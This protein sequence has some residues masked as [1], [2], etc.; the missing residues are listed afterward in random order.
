[1]RPAKVPV[2]PVMQ[3]LG[4]LQMNGAAAEEP[5][6]TEAALTD[7]IEHIVSRHHRYVRDEAP[8]LKALLQKVVTRHGEAHPEL[9]A[10]ELESLDATVTRHGL[11]LSAQKHANT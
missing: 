2:E 3:Q 8:R 4:E 10:I 11:G 6:W 5:R 1:M 7:L 9:T